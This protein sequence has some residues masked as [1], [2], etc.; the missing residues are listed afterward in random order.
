MNDSSIISESP[1]CRGRPGE[2]ERECDN[3]AASAYTVHC[4]YIPQYC[5]CRCCLIRKC[6]W[7]V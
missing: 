6:Q 3:V 5:I 4:V 7:Y 1:C 2:L